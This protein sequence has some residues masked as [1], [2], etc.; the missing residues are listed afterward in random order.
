MHSNQCRSLDG[1]AREAA[2]TIAK[3]G[4]LAGQE[5]WEGPYGMAV[6][7]AAQQLGMSLHGSPLDGPGEAEYGHAFKVMLGDGVK[8]VI[9]PGGP[10]T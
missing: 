2:P 6:R 1:L 8:G 7:K 10:R 5:V 4:L 3:I 9:A